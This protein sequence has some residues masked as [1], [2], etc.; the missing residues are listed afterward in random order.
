[1]AVAPSP[2]PTPTDTPTPTPSPIPSPTPAQFPNG[3]AEYL[4]DAGTGQTLY[5]ANIHAR[6]PIA[7]TTKM[8]TA[9][10]AIEQGD[11]SQIVP[12]TQEELDEV[13]TGAS[14]A[15][16]QAGDDNITLMYLLYA[17]MLPS[18]SDAAIVIAHTI[19]GSTTQFVSMMNAKARTLG[20]NNT[21]FTSP[22]GA[23]EDA[24]NYS[25][26]ADLVKLAQYAMNNPTFAQIVQTPHFQLVA[27]TNRH[28]YSWDNTNELLG[29]YPGANGIKTGSSSEAGFCIVFSATRSGRQLI[30]AEL[31]APTP[32]LLYS[33]AIR[34]LN[35][36]FNS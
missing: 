15:Q 14:I 11:L 31:G 2:T 26:V 7:S 8:M 25:S 1:M 16:L 4:I 32:D 21:H 12:I 6:L 13:P 20:L 23:T 36:G 17:L 5:S 10:L 22:H 3:S 9:I 19:A 30:G 33:D 27:Q 29:M 18:G 28:P 34:L 35:M 24:S